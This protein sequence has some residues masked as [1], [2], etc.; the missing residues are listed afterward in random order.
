MR[1]WP[2]R[3]NIRMKFDRV[4]S[5]D[6]F[7]EQIVHKAQGESLTIDYDDPRRSRLVFCDGSFIESVKRAAPKCDKAAEAVYS[8]LEN[9]VNNDRGMSIHLA[10]IHRD[11]AEL[12]REIRKV[13]YEHA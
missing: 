4:L 11:K 7:Q 2:K 6:E 13:I 8:W 3:K 10:E 1:L 12:V 9:K 5:D